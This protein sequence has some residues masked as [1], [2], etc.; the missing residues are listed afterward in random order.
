MLGQ[1]ICSTIFTRCCFTMTINSL[2]QGLA[3]HPDDQTGSEAI[4]ALSSLLN[5]DSGWAE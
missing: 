4:R 2:N 1:S 5:F 3:E